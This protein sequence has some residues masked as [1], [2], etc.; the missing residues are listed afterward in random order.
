MKAGTDN[1]AIARK[2]LAAIE[3]GSDGGSLAFFCDDVIQEEFPNRLVP[4]GAVRNLEQLREAEVRGQRAVRSQRY[5]ILNA[6]EEGDRL[7]L[8][9][10]WT[11]I[12]NMP[13]GSIPAGGEIRARFALFLEFR[14]GRIARQRNYDCFDPF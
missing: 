8:E 9:V 7:A 12:L 10:R 14:D 4:N 3:Q 5:E 2:Y 11:A 13:L 6:V 1:L